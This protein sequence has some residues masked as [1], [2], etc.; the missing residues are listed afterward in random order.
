M[1]AKK[2]GKKHPKKHGKHHGKHHGK[3][4][5]GA[6]HAAGHHPKRSKKKATKHR[7]GLC[8]HVAKHDARAG[9]LHHDGKGN[10]CSCKH[11][12]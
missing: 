12:A 11:R 2:K 10:F 6:H 9:C 7:C 1:A 4:H 3:K 8:G 5:G